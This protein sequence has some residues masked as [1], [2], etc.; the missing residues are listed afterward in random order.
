VLLFI[1]AYSFSIRENTLDNCSI[2]FI[3]VKLIR[4]N[5]KP[6]IEAEA[7]MEAP[8]QVGSYKVHADKLR[9]LGVP[10]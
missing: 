2:T 4:G 7:L 3:L 8:P 9:R 1:Y 5:H 6:G 10:I